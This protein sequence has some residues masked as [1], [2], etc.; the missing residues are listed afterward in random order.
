MMSDFGFW[1]MDYKWEEWRMESG[2]GEW[3]LW[4]GDGGWGWDLWGLG[5][6]IEM[7]WN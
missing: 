4:L 2:D 6:D 7:Y 3:V 5:V 1:M